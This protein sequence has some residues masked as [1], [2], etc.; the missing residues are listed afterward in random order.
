MRIQILS[1]LHLEFLETVNR[2]MIWINQLDPGEVDV[3][4]LA[5]DIAD[6]SRLPIVLNHF[7]K[8]YTQADIV[9][10]YGNHEF[11]GAD[12]HDKPLASSTLPD[13]LHVLDNDSI[14]IAG[15]RFVGATLWFPYNAESHPH[16]YRL[17]DFTYI[18]NFDPA[19]YEENGT[20]ARFFSDE[21]QPGDIV[22]THHYPCKLS[23]S[24]QW[25]NDPTNA[26]FYAPLDDLIE[27]RRPKLW[28]HGHTHDSFDYTYGETRII[29][30]PL[31]YPDH[32][33][34]PHFKDRLIVRV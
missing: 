6:H 8:R 7:C 1:D 4:V 2:M 32:Q 21:M 18:R 20:T 34:N 10:C 19:V 24:K 26:F 14:E 3:L 9:F 17:S 15:H 29:C 27:E 30:N 5:G 13:N 11:Y 22:V 23:T 16:R 28:I 25:E 33:E 12:F 31:G